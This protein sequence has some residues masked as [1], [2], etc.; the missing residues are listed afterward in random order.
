VAY[1]LLAPR[2]R[3]IVDVAEA[4]TL[5]SGQSITTFRVPI[6][7]NGSEMPTEKEYLTQIK[8]TET[9]ITSQQNQMIW[10][11]RCVSETESRLIEAK[12]RKERL[13]ES[14]QQ[15]RNSTIDRDLTDR[16][17]DIKD[18]RNRNPELC[19][20]AKD[21]DLASEADILKIKQS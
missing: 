17:Q 15:L 4:K 8:D 6:E 16:E 19:Q 13:V 21:R 18:F 11:K 12:I 5:P 14:L 1:K 7:A 9:E 20:M 10:Y 3:L 2:T